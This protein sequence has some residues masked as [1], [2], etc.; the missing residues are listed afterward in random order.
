MNRLYLENRLMRTE[1]KTINQKINTLLGHIDLSAIQT[2]N[3][4]SLKLTRSTDRDISAMRMKVREREASNYDKIIANLEYLYIY[5]YIDTNIL[6][7]K[8]D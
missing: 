1:F 7:W 2:S 6:Y 8:R 5:I 4:P 3:R